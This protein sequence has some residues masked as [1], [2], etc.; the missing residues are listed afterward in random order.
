MLIKKTEFEELKE[1]IKKLSNE[2]LELKQNLQEA[3]R[4]NSLQRKK[5]YYFDIL[6]ALRDYGSK[7][8]L[9]ENDFEAN[10][11][12]FL[13]FDKFCLAIRSDESVG[14]SSSRSYQ[15]LTEKINSYLYFSEPL[16]L[17]HSPENIDA[18]TVLML[19]ENML[20]EVSIQLNKKIKEISRQGE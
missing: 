20:K 11:V 17:Y 18:E 1:T 15:I 14:Y 4:L 6:V 2:V 19:D 8:A 16:H 12:C 9:L 10:K 13:V 3:H 7:I 5:L